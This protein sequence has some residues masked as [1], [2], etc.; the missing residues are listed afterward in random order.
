MAARK[1]D[2]LFSGDDRLPEYAGHEY[3]HDNG[4]LRIPRLVH[5][6]DSK[7]ADSPDE[8]GDV[9]SNAMSN[10]S[11]NAGTSPCPI[12]TMPGPSGMSVPVRFKRYS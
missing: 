7:R 2:A 4:V 12:A 5:T 11:G 10:D 6:T 8:T 9:V 1:G 3:A